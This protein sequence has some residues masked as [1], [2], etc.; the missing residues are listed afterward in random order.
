[1]EAVPA[2]AEKGPEAGQGAEE[3]EAEGDQVLKQGPGS[4]D[5]VQIMFG[6]RPYFPPHFGTLLFLAEVFITDLSI[7]LSHPQLTG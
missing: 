2:T 1:M 4:P 6:R 3:T 7:M 5:H